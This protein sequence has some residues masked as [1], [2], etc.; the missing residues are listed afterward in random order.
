MSTEIDQ[1]FEELNLQKQELEG[2][3][4]ALDEQGAR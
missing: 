2:K 4:A 1:R 3:I